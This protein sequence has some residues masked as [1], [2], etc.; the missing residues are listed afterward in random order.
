MH[1]YIAVLKSIA[2]YTG[3]HLHQSLFN[4]EPSTS[5]KR[6]RRHIWL[7]KFLRNTFI[8]EN[9]LPIGFERRILWKMA[10]WH[11]YYNKETRKFTLSLIVI[12]NSFTD[13]SFL[14]YITEIFCDSYYFQEKNWDYFKVQPALSGC[15]CVYLSSRGVNQLQGKFSYEAAVL[16]FYSSNFFLEVCR[17]FR[18]TSEKLTMENYVSAYHTEESHRYF[19]NCLL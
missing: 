7:S 10:N 16:K 17:R 3:M 19:V 14:K 13:I 6:K 5:S 15:A 12:F 11:T 1:Y 18:T 9:L 4:L 8:M 2:K